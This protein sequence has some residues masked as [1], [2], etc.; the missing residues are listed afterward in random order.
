MVVIVALVPVLLLSQHL[1]TVDV[2]PLLQNLF[3]LLVFLFLFPLNTRLS[4][5][6]PF[7]G[8]RLIAALGG[9]MLL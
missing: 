8:R 3:Y 5:A 2:K 6:K 4:L 1:Q 9:L 7:N